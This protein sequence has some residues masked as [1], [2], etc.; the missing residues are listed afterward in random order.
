MKIVKI[1]RAQRARG[2]T[3]SPS[4]DSPSTDSPSVR[5]AL[6]I[7][8]EIRAGDTVTA[9]VLREGVVRITKVAGHE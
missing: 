8:A 2:K 7:E 5:V 6:P 3:D 1:Y 4:T 9:E